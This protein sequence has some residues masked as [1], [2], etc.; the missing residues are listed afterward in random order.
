MN[1]LPFVS[2]ASVT[3]VASLLAVA[4]GANDD[5]SGAA[6]GSAIT[7]P[8]G[9]ASTGKTADEIAKTIS[10]GSFTG[11]DEKG[12][13]IT[14]HFSDVAPPDVAC[15]W[16]TRTYTATNFSVGE[17]GSYSVSILGGNVVVSFF[18][19][20]LAPLGGSGVTKY[21]ATYDASG[22]KYVLTPR[23]GSPVLSLELTPIGGVTPPVGH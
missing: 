3:L 1:K 21:D 5:A 7:A 16:G 18:D 12:E 20:A 13:P 22:P 11:V 10:M 4:C 19:G 15:S 9:A 8:A 17:S 2:L 14:V 23:D 6:A